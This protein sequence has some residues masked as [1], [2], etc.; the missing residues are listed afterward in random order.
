MFQDAALFP[1]LTVAANVDLALKLNTGAQGRASSRVAT[2]LRTV[3]LEAF[4]DKRPTSCPAACASGW[5]SPAPSPRTPT[6]C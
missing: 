3:H 4:A 2:L 6:S 1:W 5:R